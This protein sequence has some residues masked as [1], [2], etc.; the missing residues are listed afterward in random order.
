MLQLTILLY[1][2]VLQQYLPAE[3]VKIFFYYLLLYFFYIST[4]DSSAFMIGTMTVM[5]S[6]NANMKS[7]ISFS[8]SRIVVCFLGWVF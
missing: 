8:T 4:Y 6:A 5:S 2:T 1:C 7:S 3:P